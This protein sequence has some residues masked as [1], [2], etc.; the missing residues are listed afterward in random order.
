[1]G[2]EKVL[3]GEIL[4]LGNN[5]AGLSSTAQG[6][7]AGQGLP[8]GV[9]DDQLR[10][11]ILQ[12][13]PGKKLTPVELDMIK[14]TDPTELTNILAGYLPQAYEEASKQLIGKVA[15]NSKEIIGNLQGNDLIS[16][17]LQ[18]P[19]PNTEGNFKDEVQANN[20]YHSW[21]RE[22][23]AGNAN[24]YLE[25][26]HP[27][28]KDIL[29]NKSKE[30]ILSFMGQRVAYEQ[31]VYLSH[32]TNIEQFLQGQQK[33]DPELIDKSVKNDETR[34]YLEFAVGQLDNEKAKP[35]YEQMGVAYSGHLINLETQKRNNQVRSNYQAAA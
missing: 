33:K 5:V 21:S 3:Q 18:T 14:K 6:I 32:F 34:K 12:Y 11:A 23:E 25:E 26:S 20:N 9:F 24:H 35:V 7:Q 8:N 17:L 16:I 1:M 22:F 10:N 30:E 4:E 19:S 15:P 27:I 28:V 13:T 31:T 29:K 2:L